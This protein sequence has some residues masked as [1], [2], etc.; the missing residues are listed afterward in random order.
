MLNEGLSPILYHITKVSSLYKILTN[1]KFELTSDFAVPEERGK[2]MRRNT[3]GRSRKYDKKVFYLSAA[4]SKTSSYITDSFSNYNG[5]LPVAL[6]VLDGRKLMSAG[7]SGHSV[8]FFR[9]RD[10][11]GNLEIDE[12]E[13]RIYSKKPTIPNAIKFIKEIHLFA[14]EDAYNTAGKNIQLQINKILSTLH[15]REVDTY[16]YDNFR[17]FKILNKKVND[18]SH[19]KGNLDG[20]IEDD[21]QMSYTD[22]IA[23][24][25]EF[26]EVSSE[27]KLSDAA[28]KQL[29]I[30]KRL[31]DKKGE[32][33]YLH[34]L[35]TSLEHSRY[36][37]RPNRKYLIRFIELAHKNDVYSLQ[38]FASYI[39]NKFH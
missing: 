33:V 34:E 27:D 22:A 29:S 24:H 30:I 9:G 16:I 3:S 37:G 1:N 31:Y 17:N 2:G 5:K 6:L 38:D 10:D 32:N 35:R 26:F 23:I 12:L 21:A 39:L 25:T 7:F 4:R 28:V 18:I 11:K 19:I 8:N 13:D 14:S 20:K 36:P 15:D